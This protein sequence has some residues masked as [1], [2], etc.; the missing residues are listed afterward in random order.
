MEPVKNSNAP[1]YPAKT[2]SENTTPEC[3]ISQSNFQTLHRKDYRFGQKQKKKLSNGN[4]HS[5]SASI[6]AFESF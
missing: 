3:N 4:A 5:I 1:E 2:I 6:K